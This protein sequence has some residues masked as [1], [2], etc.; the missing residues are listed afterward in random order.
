MCPF[1]GLSA[2]LPETPN[3]S[4]HREGR[5]S[6]AE[7]ARV[8][9][10]GAAIAQRA[11][12]H[13]KQRERRRFLDPAAGCV[14]PARSASAPRPPP[15][16]G[17][18]ERVKLAYR[19]TRGPGRWALACPPAEL[20]PARCA[21]QGAGEGCPEAKCSSV[22]RSLTP[23][24]AAP[25]HP[26]FRATCTHRLNCSVAGWAGAGPASPPA[27]ARHYTVVI[28][29]T[30]LH[31][32]LH[33]ACRPLPRQLGATGLIP[34]GWGLDPP[35]KGRARATREVRVQ[36]GRVIGLLHELGLAQACRCYP[37]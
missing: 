17:G 19:K 25:L 10:K 4:S 11:Q 20:S 14:D 15:P 22:I 23:T 29:C 16:C 1:R 28:G 32:P 36:G 35:V 3:L 24:T 2:R 26:L 9:G 7:R 30:I 8:R 5:P 27:A 12:R 34:V 37:T 13:Q 18:T 6:T 33:T 21:K 31:D